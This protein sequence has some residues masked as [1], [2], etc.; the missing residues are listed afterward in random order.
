MTLQ[1]ERDLLMVVFRAWLVAWSCVAWIARVNQALAVQACS[2]LQRVIGY[3]CVP[4]QD[5]KGMWL[6]ALLFRFSLHQCSLARNSKL[7]SLS[8]AQ[9]ER[10]IP[11]SLR[12][13]AARLILHKQRLAPK[14]RHATKLTEAASHGPGSAMTRVRVRV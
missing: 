9:R 8:L 12:S 14:V 7:H 11:S 6:V 10:S 13:L 3:L 4:S 2:I 5:T 1:E